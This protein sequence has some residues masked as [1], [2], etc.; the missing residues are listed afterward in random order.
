MLKAL[1]MHPWRVEVVPAA[2]IF[3]SIWS[4]CAF[5]WWAAFSPLASPLR[6]KVGPVGRQVLAAPYFFAGMALFIWTIELGWNYRWVQRERSKRVNWWLVVLQAGILLYAWLA[7]GS[8]AILLSFSRSP[9]LDPFYFLPAVIV[10][11]IAITLVLEFT[12]PFVHHGEAEEPRPAQKIG[13]SAIYR[14][15]VFDWAS[16]C[17]SLVLLGLGMGEYMVDGFVLSLLLC[18][19]VTIFFF[20]VSRRTVVVT[21]D[22]VRLSAGIV[23]KCIRF[24]EIA[25]FRPAQYECLFKKKRDRR[26][27]ALCIMD[28]R[29]VEITATDGKTYFLGAL[30]PRHICDLIESERPSQPPA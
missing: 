16:L 24:A 22:S 1:R 3:W 27:K 14:E 6:C 19:A 11:G 30:R 4:I 12:R 8:V 23:R 9:S 18:F 29:C 7:Y 28:G 2:A 5:R 21:K 26:T 13:G 15:C 20:S 25:S 10:A 17:P